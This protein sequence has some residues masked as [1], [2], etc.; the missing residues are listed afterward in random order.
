MYRACV[1]LCR[2]DGAAGP[3]GVIPALDDESSGTL[4]SSN[5]SAGGSTAAGAKRGRSSTGRGCS[6]AHASRCLHNVLYLCSARAQVREGSVTG[7]AAL[8]RFVACF[9]GFWSNFYTANHASHLRR[10]GS[11]LPLLVEPLILAAIE[12][13]WCDCHVFRVSGSGF[14]AVSKSS[15]WEGWRGR[16]GVE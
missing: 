9:V 16:G 7:S 3:G 13:F 8:I 14:T 11:A 12:M 1:C 6:L 5:G 10:R 2:G 4:E 15:W